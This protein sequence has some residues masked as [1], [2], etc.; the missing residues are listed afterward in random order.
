MPGHQAPA[1]WKTLYHR[2]LVSSRLMLCDIPRGLCPPVGLPC[3]QFPNNVFIN[4]PPPRPG[5]VPAA[6]V[7]SDALPQIVVGDFG[8]AACDGDDP[9]MLPL[10]VCGGQSMDE[11]ELRVWED[12]YGAGNI[13]RRLCQAHLPYD[14]GDAGTADW[15]TRRPDNIR[16]ADLNARDGSA[17]DFSDQLVGLLGNFEWDFMDTGVEINELDDPLGQVAATSRWMVDTLYPAARARVAAYRNP[18]A[19]R[20]AGYFDGLDVS[21]TRPAPLMPFVYNTDH[22][23][24]AGD[25]PVDDGDD[26][27]HADGEE[28]RRMQQLAALHQWEDVK[29]RY[30]LRSLEFGGPTVRPLRNP[31]L[32]ADGDDGG[33]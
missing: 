12:T 21:W 30:E 29:P 7:E 23:T 27:D 13:L 31:P 28:F 4:Y 14:E 16:M 25:D 5:R 32:H 22:A 19:G 8:N 3:F 26:E 11:T 6:G 15:L 17:L 9:T 33:G 24:A 10:N 20:P 1:N 2:D 18:P